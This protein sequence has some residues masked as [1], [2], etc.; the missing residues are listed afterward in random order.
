[1]YSTFTTTR[2]RVTW[3]VDRDDNLDSYN[4]INTDNSEKQ[5]TWNNQAA[6][7]LRFVHVKLHI[8]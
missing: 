6:I 1:M 8:N 3:S 4:I 2:Q 7:I 5:E